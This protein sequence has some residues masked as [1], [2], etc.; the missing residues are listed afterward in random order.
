MGKAVY[1]KPMRV[2]KIMTLLGIA[3]AVAGVK[4]AE[5]RHESGFFALLVVGIFIAICGIVTYFVY[6]G[7][8]RGVRKTFDTN[9]PLL[10]FTI[11]AQ[12]YAGFAA[13]E[14]E[15]IKMMNRA[16]LM[17][18]LVFCGLVAVIG[19]FVVEEDKALPVIIGVGLGIF[20]WVS[21]KII[22]GYR[23][24]KLKTADREIILTESSAFV[25]GQ[26]HPWN[27]PLSFL[28]NVEYFIPGQYEGCRTAVIRIT[29]SAITGTL[30]TPYS[31]LIPVPFGMEE[32]AVNAA[33][34]L[35][36]KVRTSPFPKS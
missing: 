33:N 29:Y 18:A 32:Q 17:I 10:R 6:A 24:K 12:D 20:L 16:S 2:G 36:S 4:L 27:T 31:V 14:G 22:T 13:A 11:S 30:I 9:A 26:L 15:E 35:Y 21:F 19:P 7:M 3:G 25:S 23:V 1:G 8:E 28:S 34:I 5:I